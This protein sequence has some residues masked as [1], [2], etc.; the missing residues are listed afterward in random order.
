MTDRNQIAQ[1]ISDISQKTTVTVGMGTAGGSLL[2]WLS[3]NAVL[4]GIICTIL[5]LL[6]ASVFKYLTYRQETKYKHIDSIAL[7]KHQGFS[8]EQ[9]SEIFNKYGK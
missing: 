7:M 6:V 1:H 8:D 4:I 5:S 9:I 3:E 2:G